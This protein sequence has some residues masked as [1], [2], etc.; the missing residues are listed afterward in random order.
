LTGGAKPW[1][2]PADKADHQGEYHRLAHQFW[3][4]L[5]PESHLGKAC[6]KG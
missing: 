1:K 3:P 4:D 2:H 5:K 6:A